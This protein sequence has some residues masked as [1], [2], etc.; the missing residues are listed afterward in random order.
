M[1]SPTA[2]VHVWNEHDTWWDLAAHYTGSGIYWVHLV[3]ANPQVANPNKVPEGT[4]ITIP[5][6]L[7]R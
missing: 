5:R 3:D 6:G 1:A 2:S 7:I 4:R